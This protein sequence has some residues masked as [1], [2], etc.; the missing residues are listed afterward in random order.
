MS[1]ITIDG[2]PWSVRGQDDRCQTHSSGYWKK[3]VGEAS[4]RSECRIGVFGGTFDPIHIGHLIIAEVFRVRLRLDEIRFLPAGRPPHKPDQML[5]SDGDRVSMLELAIA[6]S[7][8][9]SISR[10]D[11]DRAGPSY[12][13]DTVEM[14]R[15]DLPS[16]TEL[17]FLM[18]HDSLRDLPTWHDPER[19][20]EH[21]RLG[22]ALRPGVSVRLDDI[23]A[24]IPACVGRIELIDVPLIGISSS[25]VRQAVRNAGPF[26][27]QVLPSIADYIDARGLYRKAEVET[28]N[29]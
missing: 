25:E 8:H 27:Y 1:R 2:M 18:G 14:L 24:A 9:Y 10:L 21:A 11:I 13:A 28:A 12:T 16:K 5:S 26:R 22:V 15:R 4:M 3:Q 7:A 29:G 6:G 17:Y 20:I 19:I 23:Y